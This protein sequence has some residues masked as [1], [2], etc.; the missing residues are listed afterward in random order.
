MAFIVFTDSFSNLPSTLIRQLDIHV[1]PCTYLSQG[2]TVHYDGNIDD[3]D[4]KAFYDDMRAGKYITTSLVNPEVFQAHFRPV[5]ES[6]QDVVYV[7]LSSGVSGT[8]Q[9]AQMAAAE[10]KSEFPSRTVRLVD[11]RGAGLGTGLLACRAADLRSQGLTADAAGDQ[12]DAD[13]DRLCQYFTVENLSY[14]H[15]TGRISAA[16]AAIGK[17]LNIKPLLYGDDTG[18]IVSCAKCRGRQKAVDAIVE[19]YRTKAV[20]PETQRVAITHGDCLEEAQALAEKICAIAKPREL[21][22]CPHEPFTGS[23]VGPGMLALF[24]F[25]DSRR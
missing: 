1:L 4:A 24:F 20:S 9:S 15:R 12:L 16:T 23:H 17:V 18:H 13:T 19:K 25:G 8:F 3:F 7:G 21:I 6:G 14:L 10:L 22:L 5:L 2:E 11:S